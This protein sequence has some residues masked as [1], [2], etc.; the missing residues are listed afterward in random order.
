MGAVGSAGRHSSRSRM[1]RALSKSSSRRWRFCSVANLPT[2]EPPRGT[3]H[4]LRLGRSRPRP[5]AT[6]GKCAEGDGTDAKQRVHHPRSYNFSNRSRRCW[7][8]ALLFSPLSCSP[9]PASRLRCRRD[10][11]QSNFR[12]SAYDNGD[13]GIRRQRL[14]RHAEDGG[15]EL[16]H[17]VQTASGQ[18]HSALSKGRF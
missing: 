2:P 7:I 8:A 12:R 4:R 15:D 6:V 3:R 5:S 13:A 9:Q 14:L 18:Q 1:N 16:I 10:R 11:P 17:Y